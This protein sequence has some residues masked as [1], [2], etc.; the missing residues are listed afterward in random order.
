MALMVSY[1]FKINIKIIIFLRNLNRRKFALLL[2]SKTDSRQ[3]V[4]ILIG[5]RLSLFF[6]SIKNEKTI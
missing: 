5:C 1:F 6:F 3:S 2:L 4:K